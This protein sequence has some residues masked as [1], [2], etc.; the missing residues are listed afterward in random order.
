M[1]KV[2]K[3]SLFRFYC[4]HVFITT[5]K[6]FQAGLLNHIVLDYSI[7]KKKINQR[8]CVNTFSNELLPACSTGLVGYSAGFWFLFLFFVLFFFKLEVYFSEDPESMILVRDD[9]CLE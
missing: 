4:R 6:V 3:T 5:V 7:L 2:A 1:N 9:G 8:D